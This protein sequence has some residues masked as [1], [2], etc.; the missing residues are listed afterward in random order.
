MYHGPRE[1]VI[2]YFQSLDF[3]IPEHKDRCDFLQ[4]IATPDGQQYVVK[5]AEEHKDEGLRKSNSFMRHNASLAPRNT[6]EFVGRFQRSTFFYDTRVALKVC[7]IS[8]LIR[9]FLVFLVDENDMII[10]VKVPWTISAHF[11]KVHVI[12]FTV[13]LQRHIMLLLRREFTNSSR[14]KGFAIARVM[15]CLIMG[16]INGVLFFQVSQLIRVL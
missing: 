15:Q 5:G 6:D 1:K 9:P 4:E 13:P 3:C 7:C 10:R 16:I 2:L 8:L 14:D 12:E 11:E